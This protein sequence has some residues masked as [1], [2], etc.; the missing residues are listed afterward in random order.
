ERLGFGVHN[1]GTF[2][3]TDD[4]CRTEITVVGRDDSHFAHV[5]VRGSD[6]IMA[7]S[8]FGKIEE[9]EEFFRGSECGYSPGRRPGVWE[10][11]RLHMH[12]WELKPVFVESA[13]S[14]FLDGMFGGA[15]VIDSAFVMHDIEH[16]WS[17]CGTETFGTCANSPFRSKSLVKAA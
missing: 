16:T 15:A 3:V 9:A 1:R 14:T 6:R 13:R 11:A 5:S 10:G 8:A 12:R 4:R 7:G 17:G 2:A